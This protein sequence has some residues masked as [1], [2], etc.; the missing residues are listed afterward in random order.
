MIL[1]D[2]TLYDPEFSTRLRYGAGVPDNSLG[3]IGDAYVNTATGW[4]Y[5]KT[6]ETTWTVRGILAQSISNSLATFYC[7]DGQ[8]RSVA[9]A[10][11]GPASHAGTHVGL[12]SDKIRDATSS[13]DGLMTAE[14]A[15]KLD[16]IEA[17][18]DVTDAANVGSSINGSSS[19]ATPVN[20]D[21]VPL[22]DS[23]ASNVLK[24]VT[25]AN[26]KSTL[27]AYFD[28]LYSFFDPSSPGPI[29]AGTPDEGHF[30]TLDI[31]SPVG[32][33]SGDVFKVYAGLYS[34]SV[35][36]VNE[37]GFSNFF[38]PVSCASFV[39]GLRFIAPSH[40]VT[41][42]SVDATL[43]LRPEWNTSGDVSAFLIDVLNTS[44]GSNA[45]LIDARVG[46]S[47]VFVIGKDG[48]FRQSIMS[49]GN[50]D[51]FNHVRSLYG[52]VMTKGQVAMSG[53]GSGILLLTDPATFN[54]FNR[55][56]FGGITSS[57]PAWQRNDTTLVA[58]LADDSGNSE[59]EASRANLD[60]QTVSGSAS[61]STLNLTPTW[62]TSGAP[63]AIYLDVTDVSSDASA[64]LLDLRKD[65][66]SRFRIDRGGAIRT[67]EGNEVV[68][69]NYSSIRFADGGAISGGD[70]QVMELYGGY[71]GPLALLRFG[72]SSPSV[73]ALK[74]SGTT[75]IARLADDSANADME[76]LQ[77]QIAGQ[78]VSGSASTSALEVETTWD[79]TGTPSALK[80]DVTDTASDILSPIIECRVDGV[81][82]FA[83][84]KNGRVVLTDIFDAQIIGAAIIGYGVLASSNGSR[85]S[86]PTDGV[87]QFTNAAQ[88]LN[89]NLLAGGLT[90]T[91]LP[92]TDP[93][94]PGA[95]WRSGPDLKISI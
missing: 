81:Q 36:T 86:T 29:G 79:T 5:Q 31:S 12:G 66:I 19:K 47:P 34:R 52:A 17:S 35:L 69:G 95:I 28:T 68:I 87:F 13:Q 10:E 32:V 49:S 6:G 37:N 91:N 67:A 89:G 2:G 27:K 25:W 58:R 75:L 78:L 60:G 70:S 57:Y 9:F 45:N 62:N 46:G 85:I 71:Y 63:S 7:P 11:A 59:V 14:Y 3:Y 22:I 80:I 64:N 94:V 53:E 92:T 65:G 74:M 18:A 1:G 82:K 56:C 54:S 48:V 72:G 50:I 61:D 83:V 77:L 21:S 24:K 8:T 42:S 39:Q 88:T 76:C 84:L 43:Y 41:G 51:A 23:G 93:G 73:P 16:G 55:L 38:E 26:V 40:P 20:G 33:A 30:T 44:S 4:F 90:L 15:A